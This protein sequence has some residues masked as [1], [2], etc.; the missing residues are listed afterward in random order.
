MIPETRTSQPATQEFIAIILSLGLRNKRFTWGEW[1]LSIAEV[2]AI[3]PTAGFSN[4]ESET[5]I[6]NETFSQDF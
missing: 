5:N 2:R 3:T 1:V 4:T 6:S